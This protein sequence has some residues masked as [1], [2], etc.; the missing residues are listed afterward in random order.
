MTENNITAEQ[1]KKWWFKHGNPLRIPF[2]DS[3]FFT[4]KVHSLCLFRKGQ[5]QLVLNTVKPNTII[6]EHRHPGVD[7]SPVYLGGN[8]RLALES[9]GYEK[10]KEWDSMQKE[11]PKNGTHALFGVSI[12]GYTGDLHGLQ[13]LEGGGSF[14]VFEKWHTMPPTTV[15]LN[16]VGEPIDEAHKRM[17]DEHKKV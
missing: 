3:I 1:F 8:L 5:F 17:I 2:K 9:V 14:L 10:S 7:S 12:E 4:D 6:P 13:S 16:W 11:N 15:L